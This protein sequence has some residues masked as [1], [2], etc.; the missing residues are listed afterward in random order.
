M[1]FRLG[2]LRDVLNAAGEPSFGAA[3]LEVLKGNPGINWEYTAESV[4]EITPDLAARYDGLYV[5]ASRVS[6]ASVAR[7]DCRV[8]IVARHGVGYDSVDVAALSAKG[9]AL[10]NT[11]L[12]IRRPV[13]VATLTLL[14]ALA[15]RLFAKDRITRA[16]RWAERNDLM[17]TGLVGRTLGIIGG[18]GIGQELLRVS[19]PLGMRRIVADPYA[20]EAALRELDAARVPLEQL[21]READFV[22]VA[23]LLTPETRHLVG[24]PQ[25]A[26]MKRDAC[27]INVARGPIVD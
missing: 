18:G 21:M 14:F 24:A 8:R 5:N 12:A 17:G 1:S 19:A 20:S 4:P 10:T 9:I 6:A 13:A 23:C 3:A 7:A 15:G 11:P 2:I 16:G 25:F 26:L 27:F 22:V